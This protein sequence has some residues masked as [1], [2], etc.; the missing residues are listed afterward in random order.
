MVVDASPS[1]D[2]PPGA[3]TTAAGDGVVRSTRGE[4]D[5]GGASFNSATAA[6][7]LASADF[8]A[9]RSNCASLADSRSRSALT[10][11]SSASRDAI[12]D[13][14]AST[15]DLSGGATGF[16][17]MPSVE[18]PAAR[19]AQ[20]ATSAVRPV[21]MAH[22]ADVLKPSEPCRISLTGCRSRETTG[23]A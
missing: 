13:S 1:A 22:S 16:R 9:G 4:M 18:Q 14:A 23:A 11:A 6:G 20:N 19:T 7:S 12:W 5:V 10:A 21:R 3:L 17:S 2:G 15:S 8:A